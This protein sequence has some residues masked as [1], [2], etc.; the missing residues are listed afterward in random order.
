[1]RL[2][3]VRSDRGL[4][5]VTGG[6]SGIGL[7]AAKMLAARGMDVTIIARD[8][9]KLEAASSAIAQSAAPGVD[10]AA[11]SADLSDWDVTR[12]VFECLAAEQGVPDVLVN[13]AGV[14]YPGE[15]TAMPLSDFKINVDSGF[16]SV[17]HPCRAAAPAMVGRGSGHIINVASVA[18]FL[19]I[20]GY[21]GYS[22]AKYATVGFSEALRFEMRPAGIRVACV[23]PPDTETPALA[24]ERAMRPP[25]TDAVA[26]NIRPIPAEKVATA[27]V[28]AI[29]R[30]RFMV[31]PDV[32]SAFYFRL[33]GIAPE[34]FQAIVDSDVRKARRERRKLNDAQRDV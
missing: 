10:V 31:I 20:Y 1:M 27:I 32:L 14:I 12:A 19:G 11:F 15:F 30:D 23:C 4:A 17:V 29:G 25:E 9:A 13:S 16:W 34:V 33:K 8:P 6:S 22:S 2:P 21:T 26:G 7:A 5:V 24:L 3:E 28:R 18:G